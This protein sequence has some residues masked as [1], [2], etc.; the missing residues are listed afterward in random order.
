MLKVGP[1]AI[2]FNFIFSCPQLDEG[3]KI[4]RLRSGNRS[5]YEEL[6]R[7]FQAKVY[8]TCL[9]MLHNE[10][11]AE[12]QCQEIFITIFQ[13]IHRFKGQSK[14]STWIYR[15]AVNRCLEFKRKKNRRKR[16]AFFT[17]ILHAEKDGAGAMAIHFQHP[18]IEIENKER[19]AI[20]LDAIGKLPAHQQTAFVLHKVEGLSYAEIADVLNVSVPAVESLMFRAKAGLR[21]LLSDYYEKNEK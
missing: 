6:V 14:L 15:I 5:A 16:F 4:D 21:K 13:S 9:G 17:Q 1:S 2:H 19:T 7:E 3:D 20:L 11:D 18:A 10:Q 12:D 8:S